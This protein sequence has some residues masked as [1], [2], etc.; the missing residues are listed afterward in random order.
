MREK[1]KEYFFSTVYTIPIFSSLSFLRLSFPLMKG[2]I[3]EHCQPFN[4]QRRDDIGQVTGTRRSLF[5]FHLGNSAQESDDTSSQENFP[6]EP[7]TNKHCDVDSDSI[8]ASMKLSIYSV[9]LV[10][11]YIYLF[12]NFFSFFFF[13]E[14]ELKIEKIIVKCRTS[15]VSM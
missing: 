9:H 10:L 11:V 13:W 12:F 2:E 6:N 15:R 1:I 3:L 7:S 14:R 8:S 5:T 4:K